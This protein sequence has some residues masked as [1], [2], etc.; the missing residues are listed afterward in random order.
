MPLSP[1]RALTLL[2][3][4]DAKQRVLPAQAFLRFLHIRRTICDISNRTEG[5]HWSLR[6]FL[7]ALL[8][9]AFIQTRLWDIPLCAAGILPSLDNWVVVLFVAITFL[10]QSL[11]NG[12][13]F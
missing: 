10:R 3:A 6:V 8:Q 5:Y 1:V 2:L 9:T 7:Q 12:S 11:A 13:D 4:H